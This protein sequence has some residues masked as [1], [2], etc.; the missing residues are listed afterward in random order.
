[1]NLRIICTNNDYFFID[2]K[3]SKAINDIYGKKNQ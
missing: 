2:N 3:K 1:M